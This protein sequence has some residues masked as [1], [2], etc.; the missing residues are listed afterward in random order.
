M[1]SPSPMTQTSTQQVNQPNPQLGGGLLSSSQ[2]MSANLG[3][4]LLG[5]SIPNTAN[6]SN[7]AMSG[8]M[9]T[10]NTMNI[11]SNGNNGNAGNPGLGIPNNMTGGISNSLPGMQQHPGMQQMGMGDSYSMSQ[12]QTINFTQQ[13]LRRAVGS[14]KKVFLENK[15]LI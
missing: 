8:S 3:S 5:N 7:S 12:T 6:L 13:S 14:G 15:Y 9:P 10:N 1:A 11:P 2:Q 4:Q